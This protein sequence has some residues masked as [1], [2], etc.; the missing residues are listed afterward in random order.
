M[1]LIIMLVQSLTAEF[2]NPYAG[3]P[4]AATLL[5]GWAVIG[6][7]I[8]LGLLISKKPWKNKDLNKVDEEEEV[9]I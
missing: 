4:L 5:Y 3:Y 8:I 7:G 1:M 9:A 6:F 2:K